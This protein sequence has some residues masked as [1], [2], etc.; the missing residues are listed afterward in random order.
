[1][2]PPGLATESA[3]RFKVVLVEDDD[4]DAELIV[5]E[6]ESAGLSMQLTRATNDREFRGAIALPDE[7]D[8]ILCDYGLPDLDA[9]SVLEHLRA[10]EVTIPVIIVSGRLSDE[11]ATECMRLG[12]A[13]YVIKDR[14]HRLPHALTQAIR[15]ERAASAGRRAERRYEQ[16]VND[17]PVAVFGAAADGTILHANPAM[18]AMFAC[19]DFQELQK[20]SMVDLHLNPEQRSTLAEQLDSQGE[21]MDFECQMRRVDG[22]LFWFAGAVHAVRDAAGRV[23]ETECLGRDVSVEKTA[24]LEL[25]KSEERLRSLLAGA[26][27][28]I[29]T[30]DREGRFTYAGGS[31]FTRLG[32]DASAI[33]G[34]RVMEAF[35][36]RPDFLDLWT[37]ALDGDVQ[38]DL[39][40]GGRSFQ[41]RCGPFRLVTDGE[42]IGVLVVAIDDTDRSEADRAL[43]ASEGVFRALFDQSAVG[44]ALLDVPRDGDNGTMRWNSRIREMMGVE[45]LDYSSWT[46]AFDAETA[47]EL[48]EKYG[49]L[50]SG[51]LDQIRE[52]RKLTRPDGTAIWADLS[53]ILVR[54]GDARPVRWQSLALDIT[55]QVEAEERL[56]KRAARESVLLQLTRAGLDGEPTEDF[57]ATAIRLVVRG[58]ETQFGSILQMQPS[59]THLDRVAAY[60]QSCAIPAELPALDMSAIG[61][62]A[63]K[64]GL[65]NAIVV[66]FIAEPDRPR[67]PWM[68]EAGVV[69][70]LAVG[71]YGPTS[72]FGVMSV[73]TDVARQFSADDLQ[74]IELAATII[75]VAVDRKR[76]EEQRRLLLGR[77]VTAQEAERKSI[78]EDI[79][80]DAV[81]VMTAANMR[82][83]LFRRLLTDPAQVEAAQ[84]LQET[85]S[86]ATARLRNLL[87][88]LNPPDLERHGLAAA[89][90]RHLEQFGTD[91]GVPWELQNELLEEPSAEPRILL[92]RIFQEALVNIRKHA[93]ATRVTG[94][95]KTVDGGVM[96]VLTDDGAGFRESGGQPQAGHLG[97]ASMRERAEI[98]GGWWRLSSEP[99]RGTEITTW[100]PTP[101]QAQAAVTHDAE[102]PSLV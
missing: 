79:H 11:R 19:A 14:L 55:E 37:R 81:Q 48:L 23:V 3:E 20:V 82:L 31:V 72:P 102:V 59:G 13:D 54:D 34:L 68:I 85:V 74:F 100:V 62:D 61:V 30:L 71:I 58:T 99:G 49:R 65:R 83:E 73:H 47:P 38:T 40:F 8:V 92:F 91:T 36:D 94:S 4:L 80:D 53:T 93:H 56:S 57:L 27:V 64:T 18:I 77:L 41:V 42:G 84:K 86:L 76:G 39:E 28:A 70:S 89:L 29:A 96:M 25:A 33:V 51:E 46:S 32:L 69:A 60:G 44:I 17:L 75:S 26:P 101:P 97:L 2:K 52:R 45:N 24:A 7:V 90:R 50:L 88:E 35:G 15:H 95:L 21:D 12:A 16:L 43:R 98:A 9:L 66:D 6:L 87:F 10:R 78:A 22:S 5:A 63:M 1:M 67:S